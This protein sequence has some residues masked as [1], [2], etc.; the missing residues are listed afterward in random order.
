V[1]RDFPWP[2]VGESVL[3]PSAFLS[4]SCLLPVWTRIP[5]ALRQANFR[6]G[7]SCL[8]SFDKSRSQVRIP[9][10]VR[11]LG[12]ELGVS[13]QPVAEPLAKLNHTLTGATL[14][15]RVCP[16]TGALACPDAAARLLGGHVG[17]CQRGFPEVCASS[18]FSRGACCVETEGYSVRALVFRVFCKLFAASR[19]RLRFTSQ[20][21][22]PS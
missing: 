19:R 6:V 12:E 21:A 8:L 7:W 15:F 13:A 16:A 4:W 9:E 14:S 1:T 17:P 5:P 22:P 20:L 10:L 2:P 18:A 3:Q 11:G